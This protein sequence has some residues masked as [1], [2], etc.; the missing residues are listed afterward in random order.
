[1]NESII[2]LLP[3]D[4]GALIAILCP[5][6]NSFNIFDCSLWKV[7]G[8]FLPT[9]TLKASY[10]ILSSHEAVSNL[11]YGYKPDCLIK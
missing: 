5:F 6:S 11:I 10:T 7:F 4:V 8:V 2:K 9:S 1:M 3:K